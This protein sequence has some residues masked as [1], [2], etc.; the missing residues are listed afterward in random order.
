M[1][2]SAALAIVTL[3][4]GCAAP[5]VEAHE[6]AAELRDDPRRIGT[7]SRQELASDVSDPTTVVGSFARPAPS[8]QDLRVAIVGIV[9]SKLCF[10]VDELG[11]DRAGF[12]WHM[13]NAAWSALALPARAF[14][15]PV[16]WPASAP[17]MVKV[18]D[19]TADELRAVVCL[20]APAVTESTKLIGLAMSW[21]SR[22]RKLALW[23][24]TE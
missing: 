12:T 7:V 13:N 9:S 20:P 4:A 3:V 11:G 21:D 23:E 15:T 1:S 6:A 18:L 16:P 2:R 5:I 24:L 8:P 19:D 17:A 10:R 14:S 22:K